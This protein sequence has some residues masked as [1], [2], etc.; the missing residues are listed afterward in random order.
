[1]LSI[2]KF[3]SLENEK[4]TFLRNETTTNF[5]S[6]IDIFDEILNKKH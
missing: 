1:M 6:A 4:Q 5:Q 2:P 3:E